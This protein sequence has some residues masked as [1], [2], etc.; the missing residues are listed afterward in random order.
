M[1]VKRARHATTAE[2]VIARIDGASRVLIAVAALLIAAL[3]GAWF[4]L[5]V[6]AS[7][8]TQQPVTVTVQPEQQS[9]AQAD[10]EIAAYNRG[11][12]AGKFLGCEAPRLDDIEL[13][14][15]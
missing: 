6:S 13:N 15:R 7:E 11:L 8:P 2:R 10:A 14:E 9:K 4:G 5:S 3:G 12:E 1:S